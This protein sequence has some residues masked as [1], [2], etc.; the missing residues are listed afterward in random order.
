MKNKKAYLQI[1]FSWMFAIIVGAVILFLAIYFLTNFIKTGQ[2][3]QTTKTGKEI[4]VL[5]NPLEIGFE[6]GK[7][8]TLSTS[9]ETQLNFNCELYGNFGR[10]ELLVREKTYN[11]WSES[12]NKVTFQNKYIFSQASVEGKEF[13]LFS[14]S[15]E[16]PFKVASVIYLTA[17]NENYC[18]VNPPKQI[19]DEIINL[20]FEN[21]LIKDLDENLCSGKE[22]QVCFTSSSDCDMKVNCVDD[23]CTS[24]KITKDQEEL[25]FYTPT[26]MYAG[27][28]S[29]P[30]IYECQLKRLL[31][32]TETLSQLYREK[33][34]VTSMGNCLNYLAPDL[35]IFQSSLN[36]YLT[37]EKSSPDL[38]LIAPIVRDL[39][40]K[41]KHSTCRLW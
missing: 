3:E 25:S 22:T 39:Y 30:I 2:A 41:N 6:Q 12:N 11:K 32:R 4:G 20:D 8:S 21:I 28:F 15:F 5:L 38:D 36:S 1:S 27:I 16:F 10:Q 31:M 33:L 26:L 19:S 34:T 14:K 24:G 23:K 7:K 35:N 40:N 9:V 29:D 13:Y 18:F 17:K 37:N